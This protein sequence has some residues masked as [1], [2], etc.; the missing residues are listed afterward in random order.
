[1]AFIDPVIDANVAYVRVRAN[2]AAEMQAKL[3]A[4][5]AALPAGS[6][7][8]DFE[9]FGTGAAPNFLAMLT[10]A[11]EGSNDMPDVD[12]SAAG[13]SVLGGLDTVDPIPLCPALA[14]AVRATG[15]TVIN[16]MVTAGGGV[17]PHWMAAALYTV[18]GG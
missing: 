6:S 5:A 9:L 13:F 8:V 1:M 10:V 4:A 2:N 15:N 7:I 12:P 11:Q 3:A 18:S 16:K 17:G 14:A